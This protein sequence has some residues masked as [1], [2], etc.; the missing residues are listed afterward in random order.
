MDFYNLDEKLDLVATLF[1]NWIF[2]EYEVSDRLMWEM[3]FSNQCFANE[4]CHY[5]NDLT[6]GLIPSAELKR[7]PA[8]P[9]LPI[10]E[11][12]SDYKSSQIFGIFVDQFSCHIEELIAKVEEI[13]ICRSDNNL[14]SLKKNR[15]Y[16]ADLSQ[17][18]LVRLASYTPFSMPITPSHI[19]QWRTQM[20]QHEWFKLKSEH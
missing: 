13:V 12:T 15:A 5:L 8:S 2:P 6:P 11:P 16:I 3:L 9:I 14:T 7:L 18:H 17:Q 4:F 1:A 10:I 20:P 19:H